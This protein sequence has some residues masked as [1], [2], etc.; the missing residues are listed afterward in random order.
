MVS[1]LVFL[2]FCHANTLFAQSQVELLNELPQT[3]WEVRLGED[4]F[5]H[6]Y[7]SVAVSSKDHALWIA[8]RFHLA[9]GDK[10]P[11]AYSL[12]KVNQDGRKI[13]E[14]Q[15]QNLGKEKELNRAGADINSLTLLED[16]NFLFVFNSHYRPSLVKVNKNGKIAFEKPLSEGRMSISR[17]VPTPDKNFLLI[18]GESSS[19]GAFAIKIDSAGNVLWKKIF[20]RPGGESFL[21]GVP[22]PEGETVLLG[23]SG[24]IGDKSGLKESSVWLVKLWMAGEILSEVAFRGLPWNVARGYDGTYGVVYDRRRSL[25]QDH[26]IRFKVVSS[27]LKELGETSLLTIRPEMPNFRIGA[28]PSGGFIVVGSKELNLW[29]ARIN[30]AGKVI[31][32]YGADRSVKRRPSPRDLVSLNDEF[33]IL[34]SA[35][36]INEKRKLNSKVGI[37]KFIQK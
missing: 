18:G 31:W 30:S 7:Q 20:D 13:H 9:G 14:V 29:A 24:I 6:D 1:A 5:E 2:V 21:Y 27:D 4:Q 17:I 15:I 16:G 12:W 34:Y 35:L 3:L 32:N 22:T 33:F 11:W 8:T 19:E 36:S 37:I 23:V 25:D 10:Q 28:I 26:D